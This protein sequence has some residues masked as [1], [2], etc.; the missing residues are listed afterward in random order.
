MRTPE[1]S[2][3]QKKSARN[4]AVGNCL[5][6]L[7]ILVFQVKLLHFINNLIDHKKLFFL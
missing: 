6:V 1:V 2:P 5:T 7:P 3:Q 4:S